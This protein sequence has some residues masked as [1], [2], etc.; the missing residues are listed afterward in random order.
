MSPGPHSILFTPGST[1]G[2]ASH[3]TERQVALKMPLFLV[4]PVVKGTSSSIMSPSL[5]QGSGW[6]LGQEGM[7]KGLWR[8]GLMGICGCERDHLIR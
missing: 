5:H 3:L 4:T 7:E 1:W 8:R 2:R 6:G